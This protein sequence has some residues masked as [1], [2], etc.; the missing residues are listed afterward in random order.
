M[1]LDSERKK[2]KDSLLHIAVGDLDLDLERNKREK[3]S[4]HNMY[5]GVFRSLFDLD[6]ERKK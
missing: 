3:T 4:H 1:D 2:R 6:L 5:W